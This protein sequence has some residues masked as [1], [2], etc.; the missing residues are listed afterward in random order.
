VDGVF[1]ENRPTASGPHAADATR[2]IH[3]TVALE[4]TPAQPA[5]PSEKTSLFAGNQQTILA[6][7]SVEMLAEAAPG[8]AVWIDRS[9]RTAERPKGDGSLALMGRRLGSGYELGVGRALRSRVA[10]FVEGDD[11]P[12]L[13]HLARRIG[14]TAVASSDRYATVPLGG[15]S[16]NAV[17]S[18][19]AET[20][21]ALGAN[22]RTFVL[23]D[24]DLRSDEARES[25][26]EALRKSGAQVHLW[27]RRE[28]ENYLIDPAAIA[29]VAGIPVDEARTML[30]EAVEE[31]KADT[32]LTLQ[33]TRIEER[34]MKGSASAKH[35]PK[36]ILAAATEEFTQR[37]ASWEG[38]LAM[39]DAK[40]TIRALNKRLQQKG[41]QTLNVHALAK[42]I[43]PPKSRLKS[44]R[45]SMLWRP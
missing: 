20:M 37:W 23:L 4:T 3:H 21:H 8:S 10:L 5:N 6:T 11:A 41:V 22:V 18:A 38:R 12:V 9:R 27:Q 14:R 42:G 31:Q 7:H 26:T 28:L 17:A 33:T 35:A 15:F 40:L 24:S 25:E 32:L 43:P 19:F 2:P 45:S 34:G 44:G 30:F 39:V 29:K 36:T 16:R 1:G 13:A